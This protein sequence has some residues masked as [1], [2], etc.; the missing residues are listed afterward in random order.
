MSEASLKKGDSRLKEDTENTEI[1]LAPK[2]FNSG[3]R[4]ALLPL[5][6]VRLYERSES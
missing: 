1:S 3:N 6:L 2:K 4:E 5:E